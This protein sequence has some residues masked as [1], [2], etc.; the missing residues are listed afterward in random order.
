MYVYAR[1]QCVVSLS[2]CEAE[3]YAAA[4][5]V[6][7]A[8][9]LRRLLAFAGFERARNP[10]QLLV[11][12]SA[13]RALMQ[14]RGTG[15]TKHLAARALWLQDRLEAGG[16]VVQHVPGSQNPADIGT[17]SHNQTRMEFLLSALGYEVSTREAQVATGA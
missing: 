10:V 2:T 7:E 4:G 6:S 14:R 16:L 17:R 3:L 12:S 8:E 1:R 13:A 15:R 9:G 5:C 11:D